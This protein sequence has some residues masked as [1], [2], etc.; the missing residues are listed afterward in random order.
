MPPRFDGEALTLELA[1]ADLLEGSLLRSLG[2]ANRGGYERLW[3]GQAIHSRYQEKQ[4]ADDGTYRREVVVRTSFE[5][6]GWQVS[7]QGR[8]DGLR[9]EPDGGLVVEEIKSVRRGGALPPAVREIYQRQALLYAWMLARGAEARPAGPE[10]A[11]APPVRAELVLIAIGGDDV[12]REELPVHLDA[13]EA[14][15]RRRVNVLLRA[16]EAEARRR[17]ERRRAAARLEFPYGEL[18]PGQELILAA[19]E[20]AVANREH[21]LLQ[22]T[23][24]IGKTVATLYPALRYCLAHDKRLFVLTAKTTQQDMAASVLQL[25][26]QDAAFRSLRLRAKAKMCANDQLICHEEYCRFAKDYAL[27][28]Q[29]SG[30]LGEIWQR[31][32]AIE[33]DDVFRAARAAEVCPF[34]VSLELAARAEVTVCDYNYAFDPYVSLPDF[35]PDQDL[36]DA[37]LVIDEV[38]NLVER[39]RGYYSPE[40]SAGAAR[41]AAAM[42]HQLGE[43][44]HLRVAAL[45]LKLAAVIE[46]TVHD[47]LDDLAGGDGGDDL[48]ES[49]GYAQGQGRDRAVEVPLPEELFWRL[50]P[51][52]DTAFVDYLEHQRDHRS[53][54]AEDAFVELY[55]DV[56]RFL[57]GLAE[58]D[59]AFSQFVELCRGDCRVRV[60]CKDPSRFLGAVL[61]RAHA[62]I[63]LSAT[64]SPPE[65]YTG[66]LGFAAG[67][68]AFVEIPNPFPAGN[69]RVVIDATVATAYRRRP[70]NY[71]RIAERLA[72]FAAAVPG[73]CLALF[74]S[75]AFLAEVTGRMRLRNKRVF[76]Q[77]QADTDKEREALLATLRA[78]VLGDVLLAAV[79]GGAFAEG[80][81]Y[82]GD[83]LRAVAVIGPCLPALTLERQLLKDYFEER[84]DRGFEYAFVVPGMTRVVQ[85]AGRLIRSP[86]DT[87]I[88]ALFDQRFLEGPYRKHLPADWLSEEGP[89]ALVGDPADAA[90]E[91]F[92]V[93]SL[94]R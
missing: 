17:Q 62:A 29:T 78:A 30:V 12:E 54:R 79:A 45:C 77:R 84:F 48:P 31:H 6:R 47:C 81:D 73:N 69:R 4:L 33:P 90:A 92:R 8:I 58:A 42:L 71:D 5:H 56:L 83:M 50:R 15:V 28:L 1:V 76:V 32:P 36:S 35:S 51:E 39:G 34:E 74:P 10:P 55:F 85:A 13:L 40:L 63:G 16:Y 88:I 21:L 89:A 65:F 3:L 25:L 9:C 64:L 37:V 94:R 24:G 22:A 87:G 53:F 38:H 44:I 68:T 18:R 11:A 91:F 80:V 52:L 26:N 14:A 57:N 86:D 20:T 23:T 49:G 7:V 72:A 59:D 60:L 70:A 27:K 41:Q 43:P 61:N 82:P 93:L 66:L 75:Y 2:F 67:R 19:V 46:E